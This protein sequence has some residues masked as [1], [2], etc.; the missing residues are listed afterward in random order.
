MARHW[1]ILAGNDRKTVAEWPPQRPRR[2]ILSTA[3][4]EAKGP[5]TL[6]KRPL[7]LNKQGLSPCLKGSVPLHDGGE[8]VVH[9]T[10]GVHKVKLPAGHIVVYPATSLHSVTP[11]TRGSRWAS[12]FWSQSMIRD[13][14]RR[15]MLYDLDGAIQ[16]LRAVHADD[17][18]ALLRLTNHYH[19]LLR[20]WAEM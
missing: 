11:V 14:E 3:T 5:I 16:E 12:F 4:F 10:Y 13:N 17:H 2:S 19:N 20:Q 6:T 15:A 1:S 9:D 8:L 18:P 7:T